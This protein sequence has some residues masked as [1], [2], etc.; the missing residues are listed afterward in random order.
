MAVRTTCEPTQS[1][2]YP[3]DL[4]WRMVY[5]HEALDLTCEAIAANLNVDSSTVSRIVQLFRV[6]GSQGMEPRA[7]SAKIDP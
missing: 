2:A 1:S 4:R 6:D 3:D 7:N 5:Q